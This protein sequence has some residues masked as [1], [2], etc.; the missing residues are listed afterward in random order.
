MAAQAG[1]NVVM[2][3]VE[4]KFLERG[5]SSIKKSLNLLGGHLGI[6]TGKGVY[7]YT[8]NVKKAGYYEGRRGF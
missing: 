5:F 3:D 1:F 8:A 6:K 7:D 4:D 2:K